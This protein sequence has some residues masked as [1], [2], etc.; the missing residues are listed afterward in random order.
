[1]I[2]VGKFYLH[3]QCCAKWLYQFSVHQR[4]C[5]ILVKDDKLTTDKMVQGMP[6][7]YKIQ[8]LKEALS[9]HFQEKKT[10]HHKF[11]AQPYN[12]SMG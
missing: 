10:L 9:K 12:T 3:F 6:R 7:E 11:S 8:D 5:E 1:M 2:I 4:N